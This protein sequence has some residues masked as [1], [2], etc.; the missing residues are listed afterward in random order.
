MGRMSNSQIA[1]V[2]IHVSD[3]ERALR[4]YGQALPDATRRVAPGTSFEFLQVGNVQLELVP[5]DEKVAS[6]AA[7]SV[8]YWQVAD[9]N[10]A[11]DHFASLGAGVYR[12]PLQIE[13]NLGMCQVLDP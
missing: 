7:G 3:V 12:G 6:G 11:I 9:L 5:S 2:M 13:S 10:E 4:W 1:A 8:V